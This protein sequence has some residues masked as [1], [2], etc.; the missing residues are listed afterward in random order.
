MAG[1]V[2]AVELLAECGPAAAVDGA[3]VLDDGVNAWSQLGALGDGA[4]AAGRGDLEVACDVDD[5]E[6]GGEAEEHR[7]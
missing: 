2:A 3:D 4:D 7:G 6:L 5:H 1:L